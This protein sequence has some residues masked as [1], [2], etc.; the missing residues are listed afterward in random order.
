MVELY[1]YHRPLFYTSF[2]LGNAFFGIPGVEIADPEELG[3]FQKRLRPGPIKRTV[4]F[5]YV[6]MDIDCVILL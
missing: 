3:R 4:P 6:I 1:A 2:H 5:S